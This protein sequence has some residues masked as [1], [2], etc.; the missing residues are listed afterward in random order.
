MPTPSETENKEEGE[1]P[2]AQETG[3][4][5]EEGKEEEVKQEEEDDGE[6]AWEETFKTHH[7]S[8]PYG[9]INTLVNKFYMYM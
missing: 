8:K 7:D 5:N 6:G 9:K 3:V 1:E 4:S 2:K